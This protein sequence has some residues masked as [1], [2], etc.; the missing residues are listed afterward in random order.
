MN[1]KRHKIPLLIMMPLIMPYR[2]IAV[3]FPGTQKIKDDITAIANNNVKSVISR[4]VE[5]LTPQSKLG[6][7]T[8]SKPSFSFTGKITNFK[9]RYTVVAHCGK[10]RHYI[11]VAVDTK[12]HWQGASRALKTGEIIQPQDIEIHSGSMSSLPND[13]ILSDQSI[14]G[15]VVTRALNPGQPFQSGVLRK[16]R[17]IY[18]QQKVEL[19][20]A[21]KGYTIHSQGTSM[22]N[23]GYGEKV[24]I[25][26]PSG[27]IVTAIAIS[28]GKVK[29]DSKE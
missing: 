23:A 19:E 24:R 14:A 27:Q 26:T 28:E 20:A 17:L 12:G 15:L 29:I 13:T 2:S 10:K 4:T 6:Q 3:E 1:I 9:D 8:C 25:R 5:I 7:I 22:G 16:K 11:Q 21:G 18:S